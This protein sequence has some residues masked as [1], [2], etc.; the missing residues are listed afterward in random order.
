[1]RLRRILLFPFAFLFGRGVFLRNLLYNKGILKSYVIPLKSIVVGNLSVGGTGK[2]PHIEYLI[3]ILRKHNYTVAV[4]SRGYLRKTSGLVDATPEHSFEDVGDEPMQI[5][6]KFPEVTVVVDAD[7]QRGV[8]YIL[9][10]HPRTDL[11]LLDDAFQHRRV[12]AG[13]NLLLTTCANPFHTD[14]YLPA[15]SL[16]D[17]KGRSKDA[18]VTIVTKCTADASREVWAEKLKALPDRTF[19]SSLKYGAIKALGNSNHEWDK[20]E[21]VILLTGIAAPQIF[22]SKVAEIL[23]VVRHL[24]FPDH[25]AFTMDDVHRFREIF[26][27][28]ESPKTAFLTTEKDAMRLLHPKLFAVVEKLPVFYWPVEVD[29]GA[30]AKDF[31]HT[32]LNYAGTN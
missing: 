13:L 3:R 22:A 6:R 21:Q 31:E 1:M 15:G 18:D 14:Y 11:L 8:E 28:F 19:V 27:T 32:V 9:K 7:R 29:F 12:K 10:N 2:T 25:Y 4:L 16:R 26:N 23:P 20:V 24:K 17:W 30:G 5:K